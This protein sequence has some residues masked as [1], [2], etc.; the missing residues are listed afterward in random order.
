MEAKNRSGETCTKL[1][2]AAGV[3]RISRL[4]QRRLVALRRH[5]RIKSSSGRVAVKAATRKAHLLGGHSHTNS[6]RREAM[7][8]I[9]SM[10]ILTRI[11]KSS[12]IA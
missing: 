6:A 7:T 2:K 11:A 12:A 1:A 9:R 4:V 10:Y 3:G 5:Q 8:T